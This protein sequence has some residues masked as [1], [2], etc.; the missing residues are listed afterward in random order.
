MGGTSARR[1]TA[2]DLRAAIA[3]L[4]DDALV[5]IET[6]DG[7]VRPV[8]C[9]AQATDNVADPEVATN[10]QTESTVG[11]LEIITAGTR[12]AWAVHLE[13]AGLTDAAAQVRAQEPR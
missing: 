4:P 5:S 13:E 8:E 2:G 10:P 12:E 1:L 3:E 7:F 6:P 11:A 9:W